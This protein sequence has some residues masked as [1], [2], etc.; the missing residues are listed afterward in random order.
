MDGLGIKFFKVVGIKTIE[1]QYRRV[2][3]RELQSEVG[4]HINIISSSRLYHNNK[5]SSCYRERCL[6]AI[7]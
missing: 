5:T 2:L 4:D 6:I 1:L 7:S 3:H